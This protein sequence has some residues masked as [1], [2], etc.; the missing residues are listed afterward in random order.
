VGVGMGVA[1]AVV[2][3]VV[4]V[5]VVAAS[6]VG[7]AHGHEFEEEHDHG[8]HEGNG[9]RPRVGAGG[10]GLADQACIAESLVCRGEQVDECCSDDD[11]GTEVLGYEECPCWYQLGPCAFG[12]GGEDGT[13]RM[14]IYI[15]IYICVCVCMYK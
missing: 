7:V 1:V 10:N 13:W 12:E 6:E 15:Y 2:V 8:G 4:V 5:V 3:A 11:A 9:F 14:S